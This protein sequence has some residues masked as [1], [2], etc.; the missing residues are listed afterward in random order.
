MIEVVNKQINIQLSQK[1]NFDCDYCFVKKANKLMEENLVDNLVLFLREL[2]PK[3]YV[4]HFTGGEPL[5]NFN[6]LVEIILKI[7]SLKLSN[8]S[9]FVTTNG[10]LINNKVLNFFKKYK[11]GLELSFDGLEN[12]HIINRRMK[13]NQIGYYKKLIQNIKVIKKDGIFLKLNMVVSLNTVN[14]LFDNYLKAL[15]LINDI[16]KIR[17]NPVEVVKWPKEKINIYYQQIFKILCYLANRGWSKTKIETVFG[18]NLKINN[19]NDKQITIKVNGEIYNDLWFCEKIGDIKIEDFYFK[20]KQ[21]KKHLNFCQRKH[22][23]AL[24]NLFFDYLDSFFTFYPESKMY[25]F[26]INTCCNNECIHCIHKKNM[27]KPIALP[28]KKIE[29][30]LNKAQAKGKGII[31]LTGGEPTLHP[32][33]SKIVTMINDRGMNAIILTNAK[34]FYYP[35]FANK[36]K[37]QKVLFDIP[38]HHSMPE[39]HDNVTRTKDSFKYTTG[40]IRNLKKNQVKIIGK[41]VITKNNYN[42]LSNIVKLFYD[43]D[44]KVVNLTYPT[45]APEHIQK[46]VYKL[47]ASYNEIRASLLSAVKFAEQN[48]MVLFFNNI[49]FCIIQDLNKYKEEYKF[50][51]IDTHNYQQ[52]KNCRE[53][54]YVSVCKGPSKHYVSFFGGQ[55]FIPVKTTSSDLKK[56]IY[57]DY[58]N[59]LSKIVMHL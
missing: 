28:L 10:S 16:E 19:I 53:C 41:L 14:N 50:N 55:E 12:D 56:E 58:L 24:D 34:M 57:D 31:G 49:P 51:N 43:L 15:Q 1:C 39:K 40:G 47:I 26:M 27:L 44:V 46:N 6:T 52:I 11:V 25:S 7:K 35:E 45:I 54:V 17:I 23:W 36:F 9:F 21:V 4:L 5:L 33:L 32:K 38:I 30:L 59:L 42:D 22:L 3:D 18:E 20:K 13:N 37:S 8:F 29:N 48:D 2:P